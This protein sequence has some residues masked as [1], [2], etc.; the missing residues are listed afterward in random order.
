EP[1]RRVDQQADVGPHLGGFGEEGLLAKATRLDAQ[2]LQDPTLHHAVRFR[3][4][5]TL[6]GREALVREV[7]PQDQAH[8]DVDLGRVRTLE[9]QVLEWTF[10]ECRERDLPGSVH[11]SET[12]PG[13]RDRDHRPAVADQVERTGSEADPIGTY[14]RQAER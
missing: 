12:L 3:K 14:K 5:G 10:R 1:G 7:A 13:S 2:S 11:E 8:Q 4:A 6:A 9:H